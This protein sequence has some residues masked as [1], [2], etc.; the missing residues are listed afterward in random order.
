MFI[1]PF[2]EIPI[3]YGYVLYFLVMRIIFPHIYRLVVKL[4][5]EKSRLDGKYY[6]C[7]QEDFYQPDVCIIFYPFFIIFNKSF[8]QDI[9]QL[10]LPFLVPLFMRLKYLV[11]V[12]IEPKKTLSP[13]SPFR[14]LSAVAVLIWALA[15]FLALIL[16][17]VCQRMYRLKE[18]F[19]GGSGLQ[20]N[21]QGKCVSTIKAKRID[22]S[23]R[24]LQIETPGASVSFGRRK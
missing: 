2:K 7:Q 6:I 23:I 13:F 24:G 18:S 21:I 5:L 8:Y 19:R 3:R 22:I 9:L 17:W 16:G 11:A 10:T 15:C 14:L 20:S 12:P 1:S 4:S